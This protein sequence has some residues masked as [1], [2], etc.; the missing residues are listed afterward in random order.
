MGHV[1]GTKRCK[2]A[3]KL[4]CT[5]MQHVPDT[6]SKVEPIGENDQNSLCSCTRKNKMAAISSGARAAA[7]DWNDSFSFF[8]YLN[9]ELLKLCRK[10][11]C[12]ETKS[13]HIK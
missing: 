2:D 3:M 6:E 7:F 5:V 9:T 13:K 12:S 10:H 11:L 8:M 1:V 4:V